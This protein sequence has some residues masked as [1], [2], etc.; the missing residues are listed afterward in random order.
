MRARSGFQISKR[1]EKKVT[2]RL[3][4]DEFSEIGQRKKQAMEIAR[5]LGHQMSA[6]HR[7]PNDEYVRWNSHCVDCNT[8][9]VVATEIPPII[10]QFIYGN[11]LKHSC[12]AMQAMQEED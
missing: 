3:A 1:K 11:A 4:T 6:W 12:V 2:Q 8:A 9:A 7:R 10:G 5:T